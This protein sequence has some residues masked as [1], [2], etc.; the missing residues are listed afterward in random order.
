M[1]NFQNSGD[2]IENFPLLLCGKISLRAQSLLILSN[3]LCTEALWVKKKTYKLIKTLFFHAVFERKKCYHCL[4]FEKHCTKKAL[5]MHESI[6]NSN[7]MHKE[8]D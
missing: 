7:F 1:L 6:D 8:C 4:L 3:G 5:L 2:K